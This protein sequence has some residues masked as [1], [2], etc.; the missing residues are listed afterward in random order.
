[1]MLG[2]PTNITPTK[3]T[4]MKQ[5]QC[6]CAAIGLCF[7]MN[8]SLAQDVQAPIKIGVLE[9]MS[10]PLSAASGEG[11]VQ[12]VEMA[13]EDFG[14]TVLGKKIEVVSADHQN[15]ADIAA[16]IARRW[17]DQDGV[18]MIIGL[19]NSSVALAVQQIAADKAK[20][21]IVTSAGASDLT[22]KQCSRYGVHWTYDTYSLAATTAQAL[23]KSGKDTWQFISADYAFGKALETDATNAILKSGGKVMGS[24]RFPLGAADFASYLLTAQASQAKVVA[25]ASAGG[26][27]VN[28]IK[29]SEE[30]GLKAGG[31]TIAGLL[32]YLTDVDA[33]GSAATGLRYATSYSMAASPEAASWAERFAKRYPQAPAMTH[34]GA[35]TATMHYLNAVKAAQTSSSDKVVAMMHQMKINDFMTT[36]GEIRP[37]GRV[38]REWLLVEVKPASEMK[39]KYDY[40]KVVA[41]IPME[42]TVPPSSDSQCPLMK[43][44]P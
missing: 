7:L 17:F 42:M 20:I 1:M 6:V 18:S 43:G 27:T 2:L 14:K 26:D 39:E 33:L 38:S 35:Y 25:L 31:Q 34:A 41:R 28:L 22:N 40:E 24:V 36:G 19:G 3:E 9:D 13:V 30:F 21:D 12:A 15:K 8:P 11:T 4:A 32:V 10:G 16:G 29:Q 37:N 5:F 44:T 23:G